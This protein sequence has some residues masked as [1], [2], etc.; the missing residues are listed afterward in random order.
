MNLQMSRALLDPTDFDDFDGIERKARRLQELSVMSEPSAGGGTGAEGPPASTGSLDTTALATLRTRAAL[1]RTLLAW[2]RTAFAL[3]SFGFTLATYVAR[4]IE[5]GALR[6]IRPETPRR[7]GVTLLMAGTIG[8]MGG[9]IEYA[10]ALRRLALVS[11]GS[12]L[13]L[14]LAM[15]GL[16]VAAGTLML[17]GAMLSAGPF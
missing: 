11:G 6:N 7:L 12:R 15:A 2:I 5:T 4:W 1:D 3:D 16:L 17:L 13:S 8:L 9:T 14:V 10:R